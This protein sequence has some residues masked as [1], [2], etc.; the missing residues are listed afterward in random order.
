M[1]ENWKGDRLSNFSNGCFGLKE[2]MK[3]REVYM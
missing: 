3:K 2:V 1:G